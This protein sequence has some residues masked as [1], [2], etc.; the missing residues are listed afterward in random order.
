MKFKKITFYI[1]LI[2][3]VSGFSQN[4]KEGFTYLETGKYKEAETFFEA[5]LKTY[6]TNKTA[7][8][9]YGRAIGLNGDSEKA[10]TIFKALLKVFSG[11]VAFSI[12]PFVA[13][14]SGITEVTLKCK[15]QGAAHLYSGILVAVGLI[16][17]LLAGLYA[18]GPI[19]FA[20]F[21]ISVIVIKTVLVRLMTSSPV[22][23]G[24]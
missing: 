18:F 13:M 19:G 5:T 17:T 8:L 3:C 7:R 15:S 10:V 20:I 1:L 22:C 16:Q 12:A 9:C 2:I 21:V 23:V 4:M 6:P 24:E 14:L 11:V